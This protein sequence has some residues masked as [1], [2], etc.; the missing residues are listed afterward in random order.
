MTIE[1]EQTHN[2]PRD[3]LGVYF[4]KHPR[5]IAHFENQALAVMDSKTGIENATL[6]MDDATVITLSTNAGFTNEHVLSNGDGTAIVE[7]PGTVKIDV[8]NTVARTSGS[9]VIFQSS[10]DVNLGLPQSGTLISDSTPATLTSPSMNQPTM[11]GP[12]II[13]GLV[14]ANTD[15]DAAT[16]GVPVHG[17][18]LD[19]NHVCMRRT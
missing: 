11:A 18:Y 7:E 10:G 4:S 16:A 13:N 2:I 5:L 14:T 8:D 6:S 3:L 1:T 12:V 19:G 15:A 9:S 17:L